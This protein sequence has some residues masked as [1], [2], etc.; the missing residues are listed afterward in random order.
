MGTDPAETHLNLIRDADTAGRPDAT[1]C[2]F[3]IVSGQN[4]LPTASQQAFADK[5]RHPAAAFGG[6][7]YRLADIAGVTLAG[8]WPAA[9]MGPAITVGH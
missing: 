7:F 4:H 5:G 8:L 9:L 3:Q 2:V 1:V 6:I